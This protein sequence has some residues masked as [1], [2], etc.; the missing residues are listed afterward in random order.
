MSENRNE[1]RE[2][3]K[4]RMERQNENRIDQLINTVE[5]HT[6]TERHLEQCSHI[7]DPK[8][9]SHAK[10]VQKEREEEIQSLKNTIVYGSQYDDNNIENL[11]E[12]YED[13]KEYVDHFGS[14]MDEKTLQNI[15][16]KQENRLKSLHEME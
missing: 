2:L 8:R 3:Q 15:E 4:R 11:K 9:L 1:D 13:T 7:G 16:E 14:K 12:N 6:R 5:N 10:D